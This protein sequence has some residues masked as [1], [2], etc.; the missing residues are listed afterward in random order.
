M[1]AWYEPEVHA[2]EPCADTSAPATWVIS[3]APNGQLVTRGLPSRSQQSFRTAKTMFRPSLF[4]RRAMTSGTLERLGNTRN[5]ALGSRRCSRFAFRLWSE[6]TPER[7]Q[8]SFPGGPG[9][10]AAGLRLAWCRVLR[11]SDG[12]T[13][14]DR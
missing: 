3:G 13:P 12:L 9:S 2:C 7:N 5:H 11:C 1:H 8:G 6:I 4:A 10:P 14:R